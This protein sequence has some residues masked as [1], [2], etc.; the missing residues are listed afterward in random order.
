MI[1]WEDSGVEFALVVEGVGVS[2][3]HDGRCGG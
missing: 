3:G 1:S 2:G